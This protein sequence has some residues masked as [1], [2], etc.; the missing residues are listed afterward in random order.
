MSRSYASNIANVKAGAR[1]AKASLSG[2]HKA[3]RA[4]MSS[5]HKS[6]MASARAAAR[7]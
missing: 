7:K 6:E 1:N 3:A 2:N 5:R 4:A